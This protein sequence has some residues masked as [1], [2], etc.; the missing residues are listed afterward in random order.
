MAVWVFVMGL[1]VFTVV[2]VLWLNEDKRKD[3]YRI[4]ERLLWVGNCLS[5]F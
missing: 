5:K 3:T 4:D 2:V 1:I